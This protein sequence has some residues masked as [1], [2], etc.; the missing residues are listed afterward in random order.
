MNHRPSLVSIVVPC[1]NEGSNIA[2]F[3]QHLGEILAKLE[4]EGHYHFELIYV[5]DGSRD[6]T[7]AKLQ[8]LAEHNPRVK[9]ID[10]S[11]NFGKEIAVSAGISYA[12]GDAILTLDAD[13][14]YP[15]DLI[16]EFIAKWQDGA[17]VV[18]GIRDSNQD[19]GAF[20]RHGSR[21]FY[22]LFNAISDNPLLP[23]STDY[24]LIDKVVQAEFLK[25]TER[26]RVT[27]GLID[28]LG[29]EQAY[30]HFDAHSRLSGKPGYSLPKLVKLALDSSIS[31]SLKPLYFSAYAGA[32]VLPLSILLGLFSAIEMLVG[33]PLGLRI[34]GGGFVIMLI[35][36]LV[37][38]LLVSQG[39]MALYLSHMHIEAQNRP[40]FIINRHGSRG[41]DKE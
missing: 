32:V 30:I 15:V 13:G 24:R 38:L 37:G 36:F 8:Q 28:W 19:E 18:T 20:K 7:L 1:Y 2:P 12:T 11:R 22:R 23:G 27:R 25:L 39:I 10:L 34:T 33:D 16:P 29:F 6:D 3:Y 9:I 17:Q 35:L 5:N 4:A 40:L 41:L 26:N 31:L 14:Q 21:L